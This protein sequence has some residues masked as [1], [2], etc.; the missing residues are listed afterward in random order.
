[1]VARTFHT[2]CART[3]PPTTGECPVHTRM[4][5]IGGQCGGFLFRC[6]IRTSGTRYSCIS[7]THCQTSSRTIG[8]GPTPTRRSSHCWDPCRCA[9]RIEAG[10]RRIRIR[11]RIPRRRQGQAS[12]ENRHCSLHSQ[13]QGRQK[14]QEERQWKEVSKKIVQARDGYPRLSSQP[15]CMLVKFHASKPFYMPACLPANQPARQPVCQSAQPFSIPASLKASRSVPSLRGDPAEH[16]T[17]WHFSRLLLC[18]SK[19][20][21]HTTF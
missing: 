17:R 16:G 7:Q 3:P 11:G 18:R 10:T 14:P 4:F 1:M 21:P 15:V 12:Q 8:C 9:R 2:R 20:R 13:G 6:P 5:A 19:Y